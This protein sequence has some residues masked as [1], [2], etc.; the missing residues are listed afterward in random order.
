MSVND[1]MELTAKLCDNIHDALPDTLICIL[2]ANVLPGRVAQTRAIEKLNNRAKK[3]CDKYDYLE[4][5]DEYD[6]VKGI[7]D[8][9]DLNDNTYWETWTH[10]QQSSLTTWYKEIRKDLVEIKRKHN[11]VFN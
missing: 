8:K 2:H 7:L 6:V 3:Y 1:I 4:F 9:F 11:I 10:M 5:I